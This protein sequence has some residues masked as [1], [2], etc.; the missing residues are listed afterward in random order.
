LLISC[1]QENEISPYATPTVTPI[2][3]DVTLQPLPTPQPKPAFINSVSPS[4]S[5]ITSVDIYRAVLDESIIL[6]VREDKYGHN[7]S[8]CVNLNTGPLLEANDSFVDWK[9]VL[10]RLS[11]FV[12][13]KSL[14]DMNYTM[15]IETAD[16]TTDYD[17]LCNGPNLSHTTNAIG[18]DWVIYCWTAD[19]TAGSHE[20]LFQF[21]QTSGAV[22]E[23]KW[24]FGLTN[25][26]IVLA[27]FTP[28]PLHAEQLHSDLPLC[29]EPRDHS[30][31]YYATGLVVADVLEACDKPDIIYISTLDRK[32]VHLVYLDEGIEA[33]I[34]K[35]ASFNFS[36][37][38]QSMVYFE[39]LSEEAYWQSQAYVLETH[40]VDRITW[41]EAFGK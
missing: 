40:L 9:V 5:T 8:I 34:F 11:V 41:E 1:K 17:G 14:T 19:L 24:H 13:G 6:N 23:Y 39:P 36:S 32:L 27:P 33:E 20:A 30:G 25:E 7:N 22:Q 2:L 21:R 31:S 28:S 4:E 29:N 16:C 35:S 26:S 12:D 18:M 37:N 38:I 15:V 10:E 3:P